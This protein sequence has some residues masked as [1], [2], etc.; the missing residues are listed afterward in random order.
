MAFS[1]DVF[2]MIVTNPTTRPALI[3]YR[4]PLEMEHLRAKLAWGLGHLTIV[5]GSVVQNVCAQ[6]FSSNPR[7]AQPPRAPESSPVN[8]C[9]GS[10]CGNHHNRVT[11]ALPA[12]EDE[13][14]PTHVFADTGGGKHRGAAAEPPTRGADPQPHQPRS[15]RCRS[16]VWQSLYMALQKH[17]SETDRHHNPCK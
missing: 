10:G 2:V 1:E 15:A 5:L 6:K 8:S 13:P 4:N 12:R 11:K 16:F 9:S 3:H 14:C 7:G 17:C